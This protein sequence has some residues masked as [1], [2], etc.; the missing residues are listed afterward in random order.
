MVIVKRLGRKKSSVSS[1]FSNIKVDVEIKVPTKFNLDINTSGGD[2]K[3][4]GISGVLMLN[5]S[6]GDIWTDKCSGNINVS[7]SGGDVFFAKMHPLKRRHPV[8][9]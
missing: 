3:C 4:G 2:I 6:G 7:T 8:V 9:I 5:T 1:W